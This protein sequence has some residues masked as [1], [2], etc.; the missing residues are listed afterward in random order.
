MFRTTL[1]RKCP[2]VCA[3]FDALYKGF[4]ATG[5]YPD[6]ESKAFLRICSPAP[7]DRAA[8]FSIAFAK[9]IKDGMVNQYSHRSRSNAEAQFDEILDRSPGGPPAKEVFGFPAKELEKPA[10]ALKAWLAKKSQ[11]TAWTRL[12]WATCHEN[13]Q[14]SRLG[15]APWL[16]VPNRKTDSLITPADAANIA[17]LLDPKP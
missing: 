11:L 2:S 3:Y 14:T 4:E 16:G 12:F 8:L 1:N 17:K 15:G 7:T 13:G 10:E 6:E 9:E 5:E